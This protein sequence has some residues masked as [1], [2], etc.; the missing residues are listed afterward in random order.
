MM[1]IVNGLLFGLGIMNVGIIVITTP[2]KICS[3]IT[4]FGIVIASIAV[5]IFFYWFA[6]QRRESD[7]ESKK[8]SIPAYLHAPRQNND[9]SSKAE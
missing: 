9:V 8:S 4:L 3:F 6:A 7:W 1:G 2:R 5:H